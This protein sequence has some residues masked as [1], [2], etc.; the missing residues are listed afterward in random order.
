MALRA[1]L[2]LRLVITL[3]ASLI[4]LIRSPLGPAL[5]LLIGAAVVFVFGRWIYRTLRMTGV[6]LLF[7]SLAVWLLL[8]L[9]TRSDFPIYSHPWQPLLQGGANLVWIGDGWNWYI[10]GLILLLGG[11]GI[12]LD[13]NKGYSGYRRSSSTVASHL[14]FLATA[15]LFVGSGNLLTAILTWVMM[16]LMMLLRSAMRPDSTP[17]SVAVTVRD[18]RAKG[19]SLLGALF[20]MVG[21]L[22]AGPGGPGQPLDSGVLPIETIVLMLL[23]AAIRAGAYPFHLWLL[24]T[25]NERVD[26]AERMLDQMVPVLCGLWLLGWTVNLGGEFVLVRPEVLGIIILS[27]LGSAIAAWTAPDQ[28]NHTTF[29]LITSAGLAGLSG[30]VAFDQGPR[31]LIWPTTAFA[32]GGGLWLVG[33]RVWQEWGWQIPVS[34]GALA[35]AGVPFTPGFLTQPGLARLLTTGSVF[36]LLF[37][38]YVIAQTIQIGALL[39]SWGAER[40]DQPMLQ[41]MAV[42]RLL[43]ACIALGLPLAFVG[44]LPQ[45]VAT[46]ASMPDAIP[47]TL[48]SPPTVVAPGIVW[49]TLGLPLL[50][51]MGIALLRPRFWGLFGQWPERISHISRLEWFFQISWWSINRVS[52]T[53]GNAVGIVEGAGYMGWLAV[54]AL[55]GYLLVS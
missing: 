38:I 12:L 27:M 23:A 40:R 46:L 55:M 5:V 9:R 19:L 2:Q 54:F 13:W 20:L 25:E 10:A 50:L 34:V 30:A 36:T 39:R 48:G 15:L 21:L 43:I 33:E 32:L 35:L 6:A 45:T 29:V 42:A 37:A 7:V 3:L 17:Q 52:D 51:G 24:P 16:D 4:E 28:S 53:W 31:A 26:L 44:F 47:P 1:V 49:I 8:G 18:N 14:G 22:P 11:V 41:P